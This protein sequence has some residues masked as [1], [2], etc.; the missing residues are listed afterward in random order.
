MR[1]C[2]GVNKNTHTQTEVNTPGYQ[3]KVP[4]AALPGNGTLG[5]S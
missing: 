2:F 5:V 4:N 1:Q 3:Y